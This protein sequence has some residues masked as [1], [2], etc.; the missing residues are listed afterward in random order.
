[1]TAEH[2]TPAWLKNQI[3]AA[4][5]GANTNNNVG[6][7]SG[8]ASDLLMGNLEGEKEI[9]DAGVQEKFRGDM[10]QVTQPAA[11]PQ[12]QREVIPVQS[13]SG[14]ISDIAE[15][16]ANEIATNGVSQDE[17]Y[18]RMSDH[19]STFYEDGVPADKLLEGVFVL[20]LLDKIKQLSAN[21]VDAETALKQIAGFSLLRIKELRD[22]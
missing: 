17:S 18:V 19:L 21:E 8:K 12:P 9:P 13:K 2:D 15:E 3:K 10:P 16:L 22:K 20:R 4:E 14:N 11:Q 5:S 1:M 6:G 7:E